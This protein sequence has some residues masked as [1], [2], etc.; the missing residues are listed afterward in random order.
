MRQFTIKE[1]DVKEYIGKKVLWN[2]DYGDGQPKD[3]VTIDSICY[4]GGFD[5]LNEPVFL[6]K[7]KD[8]YMTLDYVKKNIK[9]RNNDR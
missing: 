6:N 5:K 8:R 1:K 3:V 4:K 2:Q 9:E 7:S